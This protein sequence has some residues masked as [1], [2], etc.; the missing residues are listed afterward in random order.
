MDGRAL[1]YLERIAKALE[2]IDVSNRKQGREEANKEW[3]ERCMK[4]AK[5]LDE[6]EKRAVNKQDTTTNDA[7]GYLA[8]GWKRGVQESRGIIESA[9]KGGK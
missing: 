4:A 9:M 6:A 3:R 5:E 1:N 2:S 8:D 7:I